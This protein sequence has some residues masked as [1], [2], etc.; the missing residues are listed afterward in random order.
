MPQPEASLLAQFPDH[1][2]LGRDPARARLTVAHALTMTLGLEWDESA[3]YTSTAN[4]EIAME[5]APDRIRF[6]LD[7]PSLGPAGVGWTYSGGA[8]ALLGHLIERGT[9]MD[10]HDFA[11][12][13]LLEPLGIVRSEW[14][15]GRDGVASAAS[16]VAA[17]L[18]R[19]GAH[20]RVR[21][22]RRRV[23][24]AGGDPVRLDR[25]QPSPGGDGR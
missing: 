7:R 6:C 18:A 2:D 23:A 21:G 20:R 5:H 9:G 8:L 10:L 22:S 3:P 17:D 11:R 4:S 15:R 1:A 13:T 12:K 14:L 25:C 16:G 24:G 19:S